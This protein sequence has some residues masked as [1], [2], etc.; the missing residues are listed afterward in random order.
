MN[1]TTGSGDDTVRPHLVNGVV[2]RIKNI[3]K[4]NAGND[5]IDARLGRSDNMVL[6]PLAL[7][8]ALS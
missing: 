3:I 5:T 8:I 2:S 4:T 6:L 1:I 7:A